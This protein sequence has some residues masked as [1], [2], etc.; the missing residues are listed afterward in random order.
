MDE[1]LQ[2]VIVLFMFF[3]CI[4][5]VFAVVVIVRDIV[6]EGLRNRNGKK[7]KGND[8]PVESVADSPAPSNTQP[9]PHHIDQPVTLPA[10]QPVSQA[11][12]VAPVV[13][14]EEPADQVV[15][16]VADDDPDAVTFSRVTLTMEEKYATLS[17]EFKRYFD[18]IAKHTL[19]KEGVKELRRTSS[20]DYKIGSYR[21]LRLMIKR[22][23][24]VC[25]F[26]F[27]DN[28]FNN[29]AT[30]SNVR[31][32]QAAT[33]VRVSEASAVGVVKDGVDLVCQQIEQDKE[34]K[35][36]LAREKRKER[37]KQSKDEEDQTDETP[38]Q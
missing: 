28:E 2:V 14:A 31:I 20:Y 26:S 18:D 13:E 24:I 8:Q 19:A 23:E 11:V 32:K 27:I 30:E 7:G 4:L 10:S 17:T 16:V 35:K 21:V 36:Q 6:R 34:R 22:G 25:E 9:A 12:V 5:C 38:K 29:Y 3:M 33:T 1:L 15:A 37:R